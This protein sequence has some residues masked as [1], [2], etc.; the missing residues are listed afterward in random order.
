MKLPIPTF[1]SIIIL[2]LAVACQN[3][4]SIAKKDYQNL[5]TRGES[6]INVVIEIP[7]GTN[8]KIEYQKEAQRFENDQINGEDR[9]IRFLPYPGNYGFIPST[10][11]DPARGGDGDALDI[12]V[13]SESIPTGTVVETK[14]IA[15]LLLR[16]QG[17]LDTKIIAVPADS[18]L[19]T[20]P[21]ENFQDFLIHHDAAKRII[22]EWFLHYKGPGVMEMMRWEDDVYARR[23]IE[24]W[25]LELQ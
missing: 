11:M 21:I 22:E 12:L 24:K 19:Q 8:H 9:V 23:E 3:G 5:P 16:D 18:S 25:S 2:L 10:F 14:P 4:A 6:G 1:T 17:E 15:C 20:I 13:V 7:A